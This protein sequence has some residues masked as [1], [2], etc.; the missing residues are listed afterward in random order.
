MS[1]KNKKQLWIPR[2]F[3]HGFITKTKA[4]EVQYKTTNY[5]DKNSERTLHWKDSKLKINW[6]LKNLNLK[7]PKLSLKDSN[8]YSLSQLISNGDL[9]I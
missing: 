1:Y 9:F 7:E 8:G 6:H 5:W 2:G 3:G 4:A